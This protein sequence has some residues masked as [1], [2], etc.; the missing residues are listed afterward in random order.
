VDI[1]LSTIDSLTIADSDGSTPATPD[2]TLIGSWLWGDA[3]KGYYE[4]ITF[5]N[6]YTYTG[7]DNYFT[8]GFDTQ[9]FGW[10]SYFGNMLTLQSNGYGYQWRY[11]WFVNV[12]T[13]N[14]LTVITRSGPFTYYRL[15]PEVIRLQPQG[16]PLPCP[17]GDEYLFA[18]GVTVSVTDDGELQGLIAGTTYI[19]KRIGL[20]DRIVA[21]QV[22]VE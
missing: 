9:T 4:L 11:N 10:Y 16:T 3:A 17:T 22:I 18:D 2:A 21:C 19:T 12:L 20:T 7:Y 15:Q 5:G 6:D 1:P 14:A 8:Y 13:E